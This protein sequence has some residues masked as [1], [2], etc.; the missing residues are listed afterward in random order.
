MRNYKMPVSKQCV[1]NLGHIALIIT[2]ESFHFFR[3]KKEAEKSSFRKISIIICMN[4]YTN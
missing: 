2:R 4:I 3:K 1:S